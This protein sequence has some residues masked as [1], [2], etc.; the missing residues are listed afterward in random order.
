LAVELLK[1]SETLVCT[2]IGFP[3]GYS[4]T[5]V[6]AFETKQA[7]AAGAD[8]IDMVI[9]NS[10]LKDGRLDLVTSDISAVVEAAEGRI[11]KVIIESCLLEDQAITKACQCAEKAGAHFVKT[12]TGFSSSGATAKV[13][14]LMKDTVKDR[15]QVKASGG[16]KNSEHA[17]VMIEAGATRLGTSSSIEILK[18]KSKA[19]SESSSY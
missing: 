19:N 3:L 8:E 16:I 11:V 6:K 15:L 4:T 17:S 13:V 9:N 10:L 7:I 2:V 1:D 5:E 14:K 12:S 18:A